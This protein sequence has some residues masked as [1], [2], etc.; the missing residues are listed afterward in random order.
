MIGRIAAF[1][2]RYQIGSPLFVAAAALLFLGAFVDM[3]VAKMMTSGGG[4]VLFNSPH[5]IIM[6]HLLVS[7]V[8]LF[9]GAAFVSNVVV[10]DDQTGFGPLIRS[11]RI[12]K[13][14]YLFGRFGGAF[15][16]GALV[17]A[18]VPFGAWLGTLMPFADQEMLGPNRL[19]AYA[20]GYGLFALPNAL[21]I[22]AMLF[23]LATATRST[24]GTFVG[25]VVLLFLYLFS[26]RLMEDQPQLLTLRVLADP[27]G[28]S[29]YLAASRYFTAAELNAGAL[30]VT[31]LIILSRLL[32]LAV[33][34]ALLALTWRLFRFSEP[35]LSRRRRRRLRR[36]AAEAAA[37]DS[38]A[39]TFARLP[40][41]RFDGRAALAQFLA[42]AG[43]EARYI[44]SSPA[45]SIL[46][47]IAFAF[48]LPSLLTATGWMGV[49]LYPLASV[50][51]PVVE[52][53]FDTVL[54]VIATY[55][56]G[57]LVW[58]ERER[59]IH[60]ILDASPLPAWALMLPKMLGLALVLFATLLVGLGVAILAQRLEGGVDL[61]AGEYIFWYLLPGAA[62]SVLIAVLAVFV[63]A[64]SPGKY[65]G[66]GL[67]LLYIMLLIFGPSMGLE[68]PLLV[69]GNV[70][71]VPLSDMA[72]TGNYGPAAWWVRFFWGSAAALL[73]VVVHL[74]WPR[75][76]EVGLKPRLRR[77]PGLLAGRAGL[78]AAAALTFLV[79]SGSWIVYNTLVLN[80]FRGSADAQRYLAE[81]EKRY[82]RYAR[83]PQP[84]V[85]HVELDVALYPE[86][87]LAEVRGR[88]RLVNE[89]G[90]PIE[91][92][93]V[94]LM[95]RHLEIVALD[96]PAARL[97]LHD[98]AFGYRIY[99]LDSPM[100][101][102]EARSIVFRA[103]REQLGFRAS[104]TET[105]LAPNGTNLNTLEL[106]PRIGMS[107]VGLIEDPAERRRLG[108]PERQPFPRLGDLAA[109]RIT[110]SGD[111]GWTTADVT[112]STAADQTPIA[113]GRRVS[114]TVRGGRR[115]ARFVSDA[116]IKNLFSIQSGRYAVRRL[117]HGGVEH[118]IYYHPAHRWNVERM[119]TAM[120][121]SIDYYGRAFGPYQFRQARIV[122]R[123]GE[124]GGRAF[125]STVAV[126]ED[127]FAMDLRDPGEL[128]MV[129]MLTAHELAHQWWGH[130]V[131]GARMQGASLLYESL[132]Q[133]SALM[134]LRRL[135]GE[136]H[137][138][139]FLNFQL[140]R[141]LS[142]RRT[143][144]IAE[145][146][147]V[148]A[149]LDQDHINYGKG[150][151]A[152]YLLQQRLGEESMNRALR[153]FVARHRFTIAPYPRSVDLIA[154]LREEAKTP[155]QQA[156]ITDLF[157]RIAVYDLR[158][159]RPTAV[160]RADGRWDVTV[161]VTAG[162][163]YSD[164]QGKER[165]SPLAEPIEIGLFA[166]DPAGGAFGHG[167]VLRMELRPI[168]SGRQ[169]LRFVT[170]RR[171]THAGID[172][173]NLYIDRNAGDNVGEVS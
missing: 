4:N 148:S 144:V 132:A 131:L 104:G 64:L 54:I 146:P 22:S 39:G 114:E 97:E 24:A 116:P 77:I 109:T 34:L 48:S 149:G 71:A 31:N 141:Y 80:D 21:I 117:V 99:R 82:F 63:S 94:R 51:L 52:A 15:A 108:L 30:P 83:L 14:D 137:I 139:R 130:Q 95:D 170:G 162:K 32:W 159:D 58:R 45:F 106:T 91:R 172:P 53:S 74:L 105:G 156:L 87:I 123:P 66:W 41:P 147:L 173:Y 11:T 165:R 75:G 169:L 138:R 50:S 9:L 13:G 121:A 100:R 60:E 67:M 93:H 28:M 101:P 158:V 166:A 136:E 70:P 57:E 29:A 86:K 17:L 125:P 72:G 164:G 7:L 161:P 122:E 145:E 49:A 163:A 73:L 112:V 155:E 10:R 47:L 126:A 8:F 68:H 119:M 65:A 89:T 111:G 55:Y 113:P 1:E 44:L 90:A 152:L 124:G 42:R 27:F 40:D 154:V 168:R 43:M 19:A 151:L 140:D 92:V 33:S 20:C 129:T 36:Q 102:G 79:L 2:F 142:G 150:A 62:D 167:D 76:A 56:G 5:S 96:F 26:Q 35:G 133:Y 127:I 135:R 38:P 3:A 88:Y 143:Q 78:A 6:S 84:A 128:D 23:A 110:P 61:V 103:R 157:E 59:K 160:R 85:R 46:L 25:V 134:V 153:R 69:Y 115:T 81:Y 98:A 16:A 118:S 18:A 12:G 37:S 107:D 171:P 120:Q